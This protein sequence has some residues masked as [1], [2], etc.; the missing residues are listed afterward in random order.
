[1]A[2]GSTHTQTANSNYPTYTTSPPYNCALASLSTKTPLTVATTRAQP[3]NAYSSLTSMHNT[4]SHAARE[5]TDCTNT[6]VSN[7]S[8][9]SGLDNTGTTLN[10]NNTSHSSTEIPARP[11]NTVP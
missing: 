3:P 10:S 1:M 5:G 9:T 7:G 11:T 2:L 8:L 4:L 6:T